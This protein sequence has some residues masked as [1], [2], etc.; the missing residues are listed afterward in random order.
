V[1]DAIRTV[2]VEQ[3]SALSAAGSSTMKY[4]T[5][6][7]TGSVGVIA[8][9][10]P[11]GGFMTRDMVKELE[12]VIGKWHA[13]RQVRA[14]ILTGATAGTF[15]THYDLSDAELLAKVPSLLRKLLK[16][17][18]FALIKGH[19]ALGRV[20]PLRRAVDA[21]VSDT[22]LDGL[23]ELNRMHEL[24][25]RMELLDIVFIAAINGDAMG[26]GCEL[27]LACDYRL[28]AR[29]DYAFGLPEAIGG[30]FPGAGGVQRMARALGPYKTLELTLD[31]VMLNADDAERI[32]L[33]T[34]AVEPQELM[35]AA[36][37]LA[38]RLAK[39]PPLSVAAVK[40]AIALGSDLPLD[41]ALKL[42]SAGFVKTG[43]S[44]DAVASGKFYFEQYRRGKTPRQIFD[45]Y[46]RGDA[47][48]FVGK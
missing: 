35:P 48:R 24:L 27:A 38:E 25:R 30:V 42:E 12:R 46:R 44:D 43:F 2:K 11:D 15:V 4:L 7:R 29:G 47:V 45:A 32:G 18:V 40:R 19:A 16:N 23:T 5:A 21:L 33:V 14:V 37:E 39:R 26:G 41:K 22:R 20:P 34:R 6:T 28:M 1:N 13:E 31:G 10:N 8:L 9:H 36:L 17:V 3:T